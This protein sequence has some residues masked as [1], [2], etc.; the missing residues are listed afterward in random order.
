MNKALSIL[1]LT[2]AL[3]LAYTLTSVSLMTDPAYAEKISE[4][5]TISLSASGE[6]KVEPDLASISTG[7]TSEGETARD[8][9]NANTKAMKAVIDGLKSGGI[10]ARDIQTTNFSVSPRYQHF[11]DRRPPAITGYTV[12]NSVHIIVRDLKVLGGILDQVVTLG[13]N[14]IGGIQF[15][16]S[17]AEELKDAARKQAVANALRKAK[18]YA[19]AAGAKVGEV[20]KITEQSHEISPRPSMMRTA[21]KAEAAPIEA[22]SQTLSVRVQVTWELE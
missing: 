14:K 20:L 11:K 8:A 9:L 4:K 18:L 5:R 17:N 10:D 22:G 12:T 1:A 21:I 2:L 7:V 19:E 13:S 3:T 15:D 6:V 16:V